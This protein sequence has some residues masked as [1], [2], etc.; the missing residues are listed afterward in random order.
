MST[1]RRRLAALI[2]YL[3]HSVRSRAKVVS[4]VT[5][6]G[7]FLVVE[8]QLAG[9]DGVKLNDGGQDGEDELWLSVP[10]PPNPELPPKAESPWLAPWLAVGGPLLQEPRLAPAVEGW[11]LIAAGTHRDPT[12][13]ATSVA[14]IAQPEVVPDRRVALSEY[15]FREEVERQFASYLDTAWRPWAEAERR[16]RRLS[17]L[18]VQL[19]TLQQEL[20]G[21]IVE[22]QLELV[23]GIGLGVWKD[24][25][26]SVAYPLISRLVDVTFNQ[27][28]GAAEVRPRDVDPR[29]ELD[30]YAALDNPGVPEAER[31][32]KAFFATTT[33]TLSPFEP[34][35]YHPVLTMAK[36]CLE[37]QGDD[38]LPGDLS[39]VRLEGQ[40]TLTDTW[41]L[42]ARPRSTNPLMR[43]LEHLMQAVADRPDDEPLPEAA[44]ALVT[45]PGAE[46]KP[47]E[48]PAFRGVSAFYHEGAP[49]AAAADLYFPNPFNDEQLRIVQLLET[50]DGVVVQ[51]PPGTGKTHTIANIICHWLAN[52]RRV[53]VTSMKDPALAVLRDKL[54]EQIRPLA[55]SLLAS[56]QEGMQRFE[57]C[58]RTIASEVQSIDPVSTAREVVQLEETI[59]A[60][61]ARL[62]RV[63]TDTSRW[64]RLNLSRIEMEGESIDPLDA[65]QEVHAHSGRFEW[66]PDPLGV[67]PQYRPRFSA[68]DMPRLRRARRQLGR[69]IDY[70]GCS[71]PPLAVLPDA[72]ALLQA[73]RDLARFRML[74]AEARSGAVPQLADAGQQSLALA[75]DVS[76]DIDRIR[77][78]REDVAR[79]ACPWTAAMRERLKSDTVAD[80]LAL[81]EI[82][83]REL[84]LAAAER[85]VFLAKPVAVPPQAEFDAPLANAVDNLAQGKRAFPWAGVLAKKE[86][87][88]SLESVTV[89]GHS[90][91]DAGEWQHVADYLALQRKWCELAARWN[92]LAPD[93]GLDPVS[94]GASK[95]T[96]APGNGTGGMAA[97]SQFALYRKV[98]AL[99]RAEGRL[100]QQA[101]QL[102][103]GWAGSRSVADDPTTLAEL[104]RAIAHHLTTH[105][106]GE[107]WSAR[108]RLQK[109]LEGHSGRVVDQMRRFLS[110]VLGSPE[111]DEAALLGSWSTLTAELSRVHGLGA[112]L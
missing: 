83:G 42:F 24:K 111:V 86:V 50:S 88:K 87:K 103:P 76:G 3:Q 66:I 40:L 64:A 18:Y 60:L 8:Q 31:R 44:A 28:T 98:K 34:A 7:R 104:A 69:D 73:H 49:G 102:F 96:M 72:P 90:P 32:A 81:L 25:D 67:G 19:F 27:H 100:V 57:Q 6:H 14:D 16:R 13:S 46:S 77:T 48:L 36:D 112:P 20:A 105:R 75:R 97:A 58:I 5:D 68:E 107:V 74:V 91:L 62:L 106:L 61:H 53:L 101:S 59:N 39:L 80:Q 29:L 82:L 17:R 22:G 4:N 41:V 94:A 15:D 35:T 65:A 2:E 47:V 99:A 21:A 11:A 9:L 12:Q 51:G 52:G 30:L 89:S 93:L 84:E 38:L 108:D 55:I 23:W 54:P 56:E 43:D 92:A 110:A 10:R 95:E 63:D 79:A 85:K 1:Q 78:L 26:A 71:L 37:L 33:T 45:E 109:V 70:A